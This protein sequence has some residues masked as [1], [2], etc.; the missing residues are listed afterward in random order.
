VIQGT[1]IGTI[2]DAQGHFTIENVPDNGQL[3]VSFVGF[4][5]KVLK[6][7]FTTEM[8]INM[9]RDTEEVTSAVKE[10]PVIPLTEKEKYVV[11]ESYP[12]FP[13]GK[14]AMEAWIAANLKYPAAA[15]KNKITGKVVVSFTVSK[16][17]K[18]KNVVVSRSAS[19]LLNAEAIRIISSMP[20][21]KPATQAGKQV[22][23]QYK[24]PVEFKLN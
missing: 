2:T 21:W 6:P 8:T 7:L 9:V 23:V 3:V 16:T 5:S 12:E 24:V 20:D 17:G 18:V 14:D 19:P 13:G 15:A 4:K 10:V 22:D 1:T 11:V